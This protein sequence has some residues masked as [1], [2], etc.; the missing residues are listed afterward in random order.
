MTYGMVKAVG[1]EKTPSSF[2]PLTIG[3]LVVI[4]MFAKLGCIDNAPKR[5]H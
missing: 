4:V 1:N 2:L 5:D 3:L